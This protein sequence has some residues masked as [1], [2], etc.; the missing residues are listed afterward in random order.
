LETLLDDAPAR[1]KAACAK[2]A[3]AKTARAN[4]AGGVVIDVRADF[5]R[6]PNAFLWSMS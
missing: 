2:A 1:A 6:V 3:C 5:S 4:A